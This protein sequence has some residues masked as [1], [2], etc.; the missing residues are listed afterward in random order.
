MQ[1][2]DIAPILVWE[3][4]SEQR[5]GANQLAANSLAT[6]N[7]WLCWDML[8]VNNGVLHKQTKGKLRFVVSIILQPEILETT[9]LS[10]I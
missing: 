10:T 8:V 1:D 3:S 6:H 5:P 4:D 9:Q 7:L 2:P